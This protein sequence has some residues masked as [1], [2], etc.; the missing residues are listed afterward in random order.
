MKTLYIHRRERGRERV[1]IYINTEQKK[2]QEDY[3]NEI[4]HYSI[5]DIEW[6][7]IKIYK[8]ENTKNII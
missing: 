7:N 8:K 6:H 3:K 5:N 2:R 1:Y 4:A